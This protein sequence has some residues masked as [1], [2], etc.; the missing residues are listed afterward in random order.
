MEPSFREKFVYEINDVET[1]YKDF[2]EVYDKHI[3]ETW[4]N[5]KEFAVNFD[6]R[7]TDFDKFETCF[8]KQNL[9]FYAN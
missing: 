2:V 3:K 4:R 1:G 5:L 7:K 6:Q 8:E 9:G